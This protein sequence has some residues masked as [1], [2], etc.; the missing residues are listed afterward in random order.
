M[1]FGNINILLYANNNTFKLF[2]IDQMIYVFIAENQINSYSDIIW[3]NGSYDDINLYLYKTA[4]SIKI[5]EGNITNAQIND[6]GQIAWGTW[7]TW[8]INC[9]I[10]LATPQ[11]EVA[12]KIYGLFIGTKAAGSICDFRG[13]KMP[14]TCATLF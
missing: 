11:V 1:Q 8:G 5:A 13:T 7:N 10:Y 9:N 6:S 12:P 4:S 2:D 14:R 3:G